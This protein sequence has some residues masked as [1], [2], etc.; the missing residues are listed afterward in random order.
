[1]GDIELL[2]RIAKDPLAFILR[3]QSSH[4]GIIEKAL[5]LAE[6]RDARMRLSG[7]HRSIGS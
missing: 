1:M 4:R 3:S 6:V 7:L 2:E 5:A